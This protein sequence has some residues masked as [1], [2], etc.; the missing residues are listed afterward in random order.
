MFAV[1]GLPR[2]VVIDAEGRV[3][4]IGSSLAVLDHIKTP[5]K[6]GAGQPVVDLPAAVKKANAAESAEKSVP[7]KQ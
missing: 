4:A 5:A 1:R 2:Y 3:S 6:P 7:A